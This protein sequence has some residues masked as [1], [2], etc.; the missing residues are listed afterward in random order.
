MYTWDNGVPIG[1]FPQFRLDL[2]TCFDV[3]AVR[4]EVQTQG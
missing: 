4:S 2:Q 1:L 3:L